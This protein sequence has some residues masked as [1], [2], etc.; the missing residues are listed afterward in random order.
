MVTLD[1]RSEARK[2]MP[3][4]PELKALYASGRATWRGRMINEYM[5]S[6]VF[7]GLA[8]QLAAAGFDAEEVAEV[9]GFADEER[10]H[11]V[12]CGAV[13]EALGGEAFAEVPPPAK[14]PDHADVRP[15]E[16]VLRNLISVSC[17]SETV[18]VSLIG[19]EREEMPEGELRELLTR[20]WS[21]EIGHARFGWRII[22]REV[23]KLDEEARARLGKY[24]SVA[25]G[26]VE[27]HELA[28]LPVS[29]TPPPEGVAL[30]LC[31][32][33]DARTLFYE[34]IEQVILPQ[35]EAVGLPALEAWKNRASSRAAS[36]P[37]RNPTT[38]AVW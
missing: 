10:R 26:H 6:A 20:I 13:V 4:V 22:H 30:G 37:Q 38:D 32:G 25:L 23:P 9:K 1:L 28:H 12:L 19:A 7:D 29:S 14:F 24:L 16:A 35:L 36:R 15:R 5:S 31:S 17:L 21:D 33:G 27:E 2:H 18:A 8:E 11:G 34:T 3:Q